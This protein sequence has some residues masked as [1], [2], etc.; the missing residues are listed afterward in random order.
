MSEE[1]KGECC[2][3]KEGTWEDQDKRKRNKD[4]DKRKRNTHPGKMTRKAE[5]Q[6]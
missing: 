1:G 6:N 2:K 4:Q 3:Q 5:K